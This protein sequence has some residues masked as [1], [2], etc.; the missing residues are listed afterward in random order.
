MST[1][2]FRLDIS[3]EVADFVTQVDQEVSDYGYGIPGL[4]MFYSRYRATRSH[5]RV[6]KLAEE[7]YEARDTYIT[8]RTD[9]EAIAPHLVELFARLNRI[10]TTI[11]RPMAGLYRVDYRLGRF[12]RIRAVAVF[13]Y[14]GY[15][16]PGKD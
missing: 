14:H 6:H 5:L 1:H 11:G 3:R 9:A 8:S 2:R 13:D 16:P 15:E 12:R 10:C 4:L 7:I